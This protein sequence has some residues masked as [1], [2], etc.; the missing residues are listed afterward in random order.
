M[1]CHYKD[2]FGKPREGAHSYRIGGF[3]LVDII[4]TILGSLLLSL[5][6]KKG[7]YFWHFLVV[8]AVVF[9]SGIALHRLFCVKT[10]LDTLLFQ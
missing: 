6:M 5:F 2:L 4:L 10:T 8:L 9:L 1:F 7:F 3:A